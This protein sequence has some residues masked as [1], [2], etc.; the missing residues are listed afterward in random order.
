VKRLNRKSMLIPQFGG[1][2]DFVQ[3]AGFQRGFV[4]TKAQMDRFV[5]GYSKP[6]YAS[7]H[8]VR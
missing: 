4:C 6:R 2:D 8:R 3:V 1:Q 5:E 7:M